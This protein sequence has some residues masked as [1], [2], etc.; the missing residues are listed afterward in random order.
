ML[1]NSLLNAILAAQ[2][3]AMRVAHFE[4]AAKLRAV[5][6]VFARLGFRVVPETWFAQL[7][8]AIVDKFLK[9]VL[10]F[11]RDC[12]PNRIDPGQLQVPKKMRHS[13][14]GATKTTPFTRFN[15]GQF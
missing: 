15:N 11:G 6:V 3:Q 4:I 10:D 7:R 9:F 13:H 8:S 14:R 12:F 2:S 1:F 5:L